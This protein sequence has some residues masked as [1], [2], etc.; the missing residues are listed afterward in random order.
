M[1]NS[2]LWHFFGARNDFGGELNSPVVGATAA[3]RG[4]AHAS[5]GVHCAAA[6]EEL[7][8]AQLAQ[9]RPRE[10][11]ATVVAIQ[12]SRLDSCDCCTF[13]VCLSRARGGQPLAA[14]R[15][16]KMYIIQVTAAWAQRS[17]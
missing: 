14:G 6:G 9:L 3:L 1:D 7:L 2:Q 4:G 16:C 12:Y 13:L 15:A 8:R 5:R 17:L 10:A 11:A